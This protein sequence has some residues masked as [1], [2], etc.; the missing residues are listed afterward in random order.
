MPVI[1]ARA[2]TGKAAAPAA[3]RLPYHWA[4]RKHGFENVGRA[5]AATGQSNG[6]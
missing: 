5:E 2:V 1:D 6:K 3:L 4:L